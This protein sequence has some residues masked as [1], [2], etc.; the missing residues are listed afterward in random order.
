MSTWRMVFKTTHHDTGA[1]LLRSRPVRS[2]AIV[3][4]CLALGCGGD[5]PVAS[6]T[7]TAGQLAEAGSFDATTTEEGGTPDAAPVDA[8][9][10]SSG[11]ASRDAS[12]E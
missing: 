11:D 8:P 6:P 3:L 9:L 7:S 1:G 12:A 2:F 5:G 10:E 4:A